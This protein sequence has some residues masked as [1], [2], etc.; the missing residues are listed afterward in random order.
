MSAYQAILA[1]HRREEAKKASG[2]VKRIVSEDLIET[3]IKER[4]RLNQLFN[5]WDED[6]D[7][8]LSELEFRRALK[9]LNIRY[10]RADFDA[11]VKMCS[12]A[13]D[14]VSDHAIS[15][16]D[17]KKLL[18]DAED[19]KPGTTPS[20][21]LTIA[22]FPRRASS[23][24][25][26]LL[27]SMAVQT[28]LYLLFV[29]LFQ[30]LTET[31]RL[32]AE[33]LLDKQFVDTFLEGKFDPNNQDRFVD[34][35]RQH[36]LW[37][38]GNTVLWPGLLGNSD[39][40]CTY[41]VGG[42]FNSSVMNVATPPLR[43]SEWDA[44]S[45]NDDVWPDGTGVFSTSRGTAFTTK[46]VV[47]RMDAYDWTGGIA[48]WQTRAQTVGMGACNN[49]PT[50]SG[51]CRPELD[52]SKPDSLQYQDTEP[53]GY[54]WTN[55]SASGLSNPF[56]YYSA[57][58]AGTL[59]NGPVSANP[60]SFRRYPS[61]G[62]LSIVIPFFSETYLP[63][64]RGV[65]ENVLDFR[66]YQVTKRTPGRTARYF[67]VR[68][69]W[70]GDFMHQLCDPN[71]ENFMP[72]RTTGRTRA[73]VTEFWNDLK[74]AHYIDSATR[75]V[76]ISWS[77]SSNAAAVTSR[78]Q[79][80]FEFTPTGAVLASYQMETRV[81]RDDLL[82]LTEFYSLI[83]LCFT[84]FFG[85]VELMELRAG[86]LTYFSNMWNLMDWINYGIIVIAW[87]DIG[88][89]IDLA[90]SSAT[91]AC[92]ST[93]CTRVGYQDHWEVMAV[94]RDAKSYLSLCVCIQL[95][96]LIKFSAMLVPKMDLAPKVLKKALPDLIFFGIVFGISL[97]AFSMMF[98]VTLGPVMGEF[99]SQVASIVALCRAL[100]GDFD[101]DEIINNSSGYMNAIL[102]I[103]YL[104]F[105]V[106]ILLSM[107]FAILGEAQAT[108][109]DEQR[110]AAREGTSAPEYGV[111][112]AAYKSASQLAWRLP[113]IGAQLK[114]QQTKDAG[115]HADAAPSAMDRVEARQLEL[116]DQL[117]ALQDRFKDV[118]DNVQ[119]IAKRLLLKPP[120]LSKGK[121]RPESASESLK[122][123][124]ERHRRHHRRQL[125]DTDLQ[126]LH[127]L[128]HLDDDRSNTCRPRDSRDPH[129]KG[130]ETASV[131]Y[132]C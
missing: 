23:L 69:V 67:C 76:T 24:F 71:D 44:D 130:S 33:Y 18:A 99:S 88:E 96:K 120:A 94:N 111:F 41:D 11:I 102:F 123:K 43:P 34:I 72:P 14:G 32:P 25:S 48:I 27:N 49:S 75:A 42:R 119:E 54:N 80:M 28:T 46:E 70:N 113:L 26:W 61:G 131:K 2:A 109:R 39:A 78:S 66:D 62:Y 64:Q 56:R 1:A 86:I 55:A 31:L 82:D 127:D 87:F 3:L 89:Y 63:D 83:L 58:E 22:N 52:Q 37:E 10:K 81:D 17:L 105:A 90:R 84:A 30:S 101:I 59:P 108:L 4:P 12:P 36:E 132:S 8:M 60:A 91:S 85:L 110:E 106:F 121:D 47:D 19:E 129:G 79:F 126:H 16:A 7:G 100:F 95:L 38:W 104:F 5:I 50:I 9:M 68:I 98:Y 29:L 20:P 74:R 128:Q 122:A 125:G 77:A 114:Q 15:M 115:E 21:P 92:S 35:R 53:F 73:A 45:C 103:S 57:A 93:L 40:N 13:A 97:L 51:E 107:F 112:D 65:A 117:S 118:G 6:G 124:R 116:S